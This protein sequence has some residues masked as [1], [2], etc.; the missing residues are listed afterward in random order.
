MDAAAHTRQGLAGSGGGR[1]LHLGALQAAK[2]ISGAVG[3]GLDVLHN[4]AYRRTGQPDC[5]SLLE[6]ISSFPYHPRP[7]P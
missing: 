6:M 5:S 4:E 2:V 7:Y 3:F 1:R